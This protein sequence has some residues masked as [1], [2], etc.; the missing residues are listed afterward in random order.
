MNEEDTPELAEAV[1]RLPEEEQN[2]RM[3]R[4]KRALD[5]SMKHQLLPK[6]EWTKPEE[7]TLQTYE[8]VV[9]NSFSFTWLAAG[10]F[11]SDCSTVLLQNLCTR[12]GTSSR[13][14]SSKKYLK[15]I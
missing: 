9:R 3:F 7:V 11:D 4:I 14:F 13:M 1:R 10:N 8:P 15:C 6:E 12:Q 5:L 2:L